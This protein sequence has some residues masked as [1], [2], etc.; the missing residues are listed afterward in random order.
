MDSAAFSEKGTSSKIIVVAD[1]DIARNDVNPRS[2]QPQ[3]LG[4]DPIAGYTFA[5]QDLLL[6]MMSFLMEENGLISAR[7]KEVKIRPLDKEKVKNERAFWQAVNIAMPLALLI[8]FGLGRA[9]MRK[10]KYASF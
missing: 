1:G 7:N 3:A 10:K 8:A 6:N 9:W 2:G 4:F 5:N